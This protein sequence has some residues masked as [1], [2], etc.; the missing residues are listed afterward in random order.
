MTSNVVKVDWDFNGFSKCVNLAAPSANGHA[1]RY[2]EFGS[3][4]WNQMTSAG[5]P[6]FT[7]LTLT[8]NL[9]VQGNSTIGDAA[10]D[11]VTLNAQAWTLP[12]TT[13]WTLTKTAQA[14]VAE[15][16][17]KMTVSDD[18]SSYFQII[19]G[20]TTGNVFAPTF[21]GVQSG[22]S[23]ALSFFGS[24]T[25][26]S[27]SNPI[28]LFLARTAAG[29]SITTRNIVEFW[30][31]VQA[32]L[33]ITAGYNLQLCGPSTSPTLAASVAD[34]VSLAPVDTV[35]GDRNL[36]ARPELG[37]NNRLTGLSCRVAADFTRGTTTLA[38]ITGLTRNVAAGE[39]YAFRAV[40]FTTSTNTVGVKFAIGGTA[41]AT[42]IIADA[43]VI[44]ASVLKVVGT[45]RVT[46]MATAFGDV[47][48]VTAALV[49]IEGQ[50]LVNA[51][52]SLTVQFG[53]NASSASASTVKAGS[54]FELISIGS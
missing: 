16:L 40:I 31:L 44:D 41:T 12:Q 52:G 8:G 51:A 42:S 4:N 37:Q 1:M 34:Q 6:Q 28:L 13:P 43:H 50:I 32:A 46:A 35:A 54:Y 17:V 18:T 3:T 19:N 26:D 25:T 49:I 27:G 9:S 14:G 10:A 2:D 36:Y 53:Q 22:N 45:Q 11:A 15:T 20:T 47:T 33:K 21:E 5:S 48:A 23:T 38:D 29:G 24:G 39:I 7:G 30:N